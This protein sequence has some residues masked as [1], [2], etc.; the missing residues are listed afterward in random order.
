MTGGDMICCSGLC[1][2]FY[3]LGHFENVYDDDD[4]DDAIATGHRYLFYVYNTHTQMA[5]ISPI[6]RLGHTHTRLTA[7]FL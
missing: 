7:L 3:C 4:D 5:N 2:S 1:N 6:I